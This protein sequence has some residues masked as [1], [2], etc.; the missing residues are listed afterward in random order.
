[1]AQAADCDC[2]LLTSQRFLRKLLVIVIVMLTMPMCT[3]PYIP[4]RERTAEYRS[5]HIQLN[6]LAFFLRNKISV[7][8]SK[9][10]FSS[11]WPTY[12]ILPISGK[13]RG[14]RPCNFEV[15]LSYAA[16][17]GTPPT[18]SWS[19]YLSVRGLLSLSIFRQ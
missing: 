12:L 1:M 9:T 14:R 15:L 17:W 11:I 2:E 16:G 10:E 6:F 13:G 18:A 4:A 7:L 19:Q 3:R 5:R 8:S